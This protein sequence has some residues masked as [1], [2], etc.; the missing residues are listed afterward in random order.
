MCRSTGARGLY[1]YIRESNGRG[2]PLLFLCLKIVYN[3]GMSEIEILT[4]NRIIKCKNCGAKF[5]AQDKFCP[6]CGSVNDIGDELEYQKK[7]EDIREDL[8]ELGDVSKEAYIAETKINAKRISVIVVII[9]AVAIIAGFFIPKIVLSVQKAKTERVVDDLKWEK[10][11]YAKLDDMYDRG[12]FEALGEFYKDYYLSMEWENHSVY[13]WQHNKFMEVYQVYMDMKDNLR[14]C[15]DYP[16]NVDGTKAYVFENCVKLIMTDWEKSD[17]EKMLN[18]SDY[19]N[20]NKY[21]KEAYLVLDEH[22]H[23][24]KDD[25][26]M[27][28][29]ELFDYSI[30]S[31]YPDGRMCS[32]KGRKL[33]WY[34]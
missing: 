4:E 19:Q 22:F 25:L 3:R 10:E 28:R 5:S 29:D 34:P 20:I 18:D 13:G 11:T 27:M 33:E 1:F 24:S 26:E 2:K 14:F 15:T 9:A 30:S 17:Y 8:D 12:D 32:E 7:L 6:Y 31:V 23:V 21:I 16:E